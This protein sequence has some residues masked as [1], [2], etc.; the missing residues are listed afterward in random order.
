MFDWNDRKQVIKTMQIYGDYLEYA[1]EE[2]KDDEIVVLEAIKSYPYAIKYSSQR[3]RSNKK[4]VMQASQIGYTLEYVS[5]KLRDNKRIVLN[6]VKLN[7]NSLK[8]ASDRL[9]NNKK[10]V[11]EAIKYDGAIIE[12]A[13]ERL[14]NNKKIALKA[15]KNNYYGFQYLSNKLKTN[16]PFLLNAVKIDG[17]IITLVPSEV[18]DN[19]EEINLI[20]DIALKNVDKDIEKYKYDY[21]NIETIKSIIERKKHE[22]MLNKSLKKD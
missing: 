11:L 9:K 15:I 2:I 7:G 20:I 13:S 19:S 3:L 10:I 8:Y 6:S 1:P 17:N 14:R 16:K 12:F 18:F 21:P 4:F 22:Y 5:E